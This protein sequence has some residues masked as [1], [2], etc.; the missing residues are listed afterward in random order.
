MQTKVPEAVGPLPGWRSPMRRMSA[1]QVRLANSHKQMKS[2]APAARIIVPSG[3]AAR[4]PEPRAIRLQPRQRG[5]P[6]TELAGR[7]GVLGGLLADYNI[8]AAAVA[9]AGPAYHHRPPCAVQ[10]SDS[11]VI[12]PVVEEP[13]PASPLL[14]ARRPDQPSLLGAIGAK[15]G[16]ANI[17]KATLRVTV[18]SALAKG[19]TAGIGALIFRQS[20]ASLAA[21][22]DPRT[23]P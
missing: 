23:C 15:G 17:M 3:F 7:A 11:R 14:P 16:R 4:Q 19:L 5:R 2:M 21:G 1:V 20:E 6:A 9:G 22:P 12:R 8:G 10:P 13:E 18:W